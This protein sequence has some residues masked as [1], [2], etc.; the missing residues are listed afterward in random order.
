M[1]GDFYFYFGDIRYDLE[2][3]QEAGEIVDWYWHTVD[4]KNDYINYRSWCMG[5]KDLLPLNSNK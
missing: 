1:I 3:N 2:T 5:A 4:E